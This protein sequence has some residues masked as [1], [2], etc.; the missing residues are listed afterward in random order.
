MDA[1]EGSKGQQ[2]TITET[3]FKIA[4]IKPNK[5]TKL[6]F[7]YVTEMCIIHRLRWKSR[8]LLFDLFVGIYPSLSIFLWMSWMYGP[9][10][11]FFKNEL[12]W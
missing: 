4:L 7:F 11:M 10:E 2:V 8:K 12:F 6:S 5:T 3:I 1:S 9:V